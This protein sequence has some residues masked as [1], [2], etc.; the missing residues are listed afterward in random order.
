ML[1][2]CSIL[3]DAFI[4]KTELSEQ[5]MVGDSTALCIII[6]FVAIVSSDYWRWLV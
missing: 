3:A 5:V 1:L 6:L 2:P 4:N